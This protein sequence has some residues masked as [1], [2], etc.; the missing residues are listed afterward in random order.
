MLHIQRVVR[1]IAPGL[2]P[3]TLTRL[4]PSVDSLHN[5]QFG[6]VNHSRTNQT[7][8]MGITIDNI[9]EKVKAGGVLRTTSGTQNSTRLTFTVD[10]HT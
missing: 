8:T 6:S 3:S 10:A 4:S 9:N 5:I 7:R 1:R 2:L